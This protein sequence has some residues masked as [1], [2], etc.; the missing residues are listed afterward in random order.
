[1]ASE[2][3]IKKW[4]ESNHPDLLKLQKLGNVSAGI[5]TSNGFKI[6]WK[7]VDWQPIGAA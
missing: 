3:V 1:M 4:A 5:V 7:L 2:F 6:K